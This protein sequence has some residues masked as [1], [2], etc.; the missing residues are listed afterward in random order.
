MEFKYISRFEVKANFSKNDFVKGSF[1]SKANMG[2]DELKSLLPEEDEIKNNPDLLYTCFNAAVVNLINLNGDGITTEGAKQLVASCKMKPMNI[3]HERENIVGVITN[4]GFSSFGDNKILTPQELSDDPFNI[5][6][7]AIVWKLSNREFSSF[8][9]SSQDENGCFYKEVSTSWEVGFN[10][11]KLAIG[12]K[13]LRKAKIVDTEEEIESYSKHLVS[14]GGTGFTPE[15]EEVYRVIDGECRFLG[16]AFTTNPAAA[17]KGVVSVDYKSLSSQDS[18]SAKIEIEIEEEGE[19]EED[20]EE[21]DDKKKVI[22]EGEDD[23]GEEMDDEEEAKCKDKAKAEKHSKDK[24]DL[25]DSR[26]SA[27]PVGPPGVAGIEVIPPTIINKNDKQI[28]SKKKNRVIKYMKYKNIDELVDHLHEAAA[29]DVREFIVSQVKDAND[30]FVSIKSEKEANDK[31]LANALANLK[32]FED[33]SETLKQE[34]SQLKA[35]LKLQEDQTKFSERMD[36]LKEEFDIDQAAA[37]A[38]S[39]RIVGLSDESFAEWLEDF[40]PLLKPK[41]SSQ[42]QDL[43]TKASVNSPIPNSQDSK[44]KKSTEWTNT[45]SRVKVEIN[46][47]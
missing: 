4:Y 26:G 44:E 47:K 32:S 12:S 38:I 41:T 27:G 11:Y 10:S 20:E 13:D 17:V 28:S 45:L 37:K 42:E 1:V 22:K 23:E 8:I 29:S 7:A 34:I 15:G 2:L 39:K 40:K 30:S 5:S 14:M 9:E 43:E 31:E 6:L 16:C 25:D 46:T 24:K 33:Q 19:E 21:E 36:S 35:T 3:E 18:K